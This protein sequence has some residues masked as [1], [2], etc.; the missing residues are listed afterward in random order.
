M[1]CAYCGNTY[2]AAA[3]GAAGCGVGQ[4]NG[5][6]FTYAG[7]PGYGGGRCINAYGE[8]CPAAQ[9]GCVGNGGVMCG[10]EPGYYTSQRTNTGNG[11]IVG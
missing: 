1:G 2:I 11:T 4:G 9:W 3:P 8:C 7:R 6:A 5:A 10:I